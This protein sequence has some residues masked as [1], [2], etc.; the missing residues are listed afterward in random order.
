M[1]FKSNYK[2]S[3]HTLI[4]NFFLTQRYLLSVTPCNLDTEI[5]PPQSIISVWSQLF[6]EG[7]CL[8]LGIAS[9]K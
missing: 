4:K 2:Y 8:I 5:K 6:T 3:M 9:T 1:M 7:N